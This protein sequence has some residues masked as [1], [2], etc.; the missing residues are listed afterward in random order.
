[1][2]AVIGQFDGILPYGQQKFE[3]IPEPMSWNTVSSI[4]RLTSEIN[5]P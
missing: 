4:E 5:Y 3:D 1:M 2:Q